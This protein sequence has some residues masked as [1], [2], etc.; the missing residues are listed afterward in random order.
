MELKQRILVVDDNLPQRIIH[1]SYLKE[2]GYE[3]ELAEDGFAA[4]ASLKL[5]IDLIILDLKMPGMD[6]YEVTKKIR[7]DP[8]YFNI[9]I[10]VVSSLSSDVEYLRALEAGANEFILKPFNKAELKIRLQ[11][12]LRMKEAQDA[13]KDNQK[14]LE[15]QVDKRTKDLREALKKMS[16]AQRLQ[17]QA[18]IDTIERLSLAAEYKDEVTA[19]HIKRI[20]HYSNLLANKLKLTPKDSEILYYASP[21]HDVGKLGIPDAI[22]LKPG[23]LN[24]KEWDIMKQHSSIGAKILDG[25]SSNLLEIGKVIAIS[26]HEKW[27]GSGYPKELKGKNISIEGRIVAVADAFDAMTSKRPYKD[28]FSAEKSFKIIEEAIGKHFDPEIAG[29]FLE[30]KNEVLKIAEKY[31]DDRSH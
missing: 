23:S 14:E 28:P 3:V 29:A 13:L 21:M 8:E 2:L 15:S 11:S 16:E 31:R 1:E 7:Q 25:S 5:G 27:G 4:I 26:H 18:H 24:S 17:Y 12:L 20:S 30:E 10:I 6:G 9:P 22:L 19:F